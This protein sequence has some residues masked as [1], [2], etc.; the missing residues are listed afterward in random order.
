MFSR[1]MTRAST[2]EEST[3]ARSLSATYP[4]SIAG[5]SRSLLRN[6][7]TETMRA[8]GASREELDS[9]AGGGAAVAQ[10]QAART[11]KDRMR[12]RRIVPAIA[13]AL[14]FPAD[15]QLVV[16]HTQD[17]FSTL[18]QIAEEDALGERLLQGSLDQPRHRPRSELRREAVVGQPPPRLREQLQL[19]ALFAELDPQLVDL[20]VDDP[21]HDLH[22]QAGERDP[23]VEPVAEL[24][25]EGALDRLL[26][27]APG[28]G[29]EI[30]RRHLLPSLVPATMKL[31]VPAPNPTRAAVRSRAPA[32]VV[33][34]RT[35]W[36]KSLCRPL[37]SVR[38]AWSITW[39]RMSNTSGCAFSISSS[40]NTACGCLR[41]ASVSRP[42]CSKPTYPGGAPIR[43][44]TV[45]FSMY[46][47]MS[48]RISGTPM[49]R[50][51]C[52]ASSVLPT[53]VGP[54]KRKLPIGLVG[55]PNP[56]RERRMALA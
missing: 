53:P 8:A 20:L 50:P 35:T 45:C 23:A 21:L 7:S 27:V 2:P 36:R 29:V 47:D 48:N 38:V 34:I 10:A 39:S 46:S 13:R 24:R 41:M 1:L 5:P 15:A 19:D 54:E 6:S 22:R 18:F 51:S 40:S 12:I 44:L 11:R 52:F 56:E 14:S 31:R 43:R 26:G 16:L 55:E 9:A 25:A 33:K 4:A 32:L 17:H 30:E 49:I 28:A 3:S 37:L 42:P